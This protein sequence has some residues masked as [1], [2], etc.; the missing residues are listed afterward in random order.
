MKENATYGDRLFG[1]N[2][3]GVSGIELISDNN[4]TPLIDKALA[5]PDVEGFEEE[6]TL[7]TGHHYKTILTLAPAILDALEK[8]AIRR[9]FVIAGCDAPGKGRDYFRELALS[10][11]EDCV[12]VTSSCGKFRFN[13]IDFGTVPGTEIPRYLDLGQCNDSNGAVEIA[14]ALSKATGI[15]VNELPISI[16]LMWMEQKAVLILLSLLS[17]GIKDIYLGP[18]APQFLNEDIMSFLS[19]NF[20]LSLI[21]KV[22]DDL[23]KMLGVEEMEEELVTA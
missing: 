5:S 20:N 11:P 21:S 15:G 19:E 14:L 9:F 2:V 12:I 10:L 3:T 4:F 1:Y 6:T 22:K 13:D 7:T 18:S 17:L 16:T 8:K 23:P